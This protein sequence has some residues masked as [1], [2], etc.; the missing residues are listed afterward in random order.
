[1]GSLFLRID[2]F[3]LSDRVLGSFAKMSDNNYFSKSR[4][5]LRAQV[6]KLCSKINTDLDRMSF[7][8]K[9][10]NLAKLEHMM[11][12]MKTLDKEFGSRMP[13]DSSEGLRNR[14]FL[15]LCE[16]V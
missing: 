10:T 7:A 4:G 16:P 12:E 8:D 1:M 6:T 9:Q 3:L 11:S 5:Y 14:L 2:T 13:T 15:S